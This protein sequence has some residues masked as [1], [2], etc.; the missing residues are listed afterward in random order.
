MVKVI[1]PM[2]K[3]LNER[4]ERLGISCSVL[5]RRTGISLR[6]VQR[7]LSGEETNPGFSTVAGL[8]RE[9]GVGV[10]FDDEVDVRTIRRRQ[11]ERKAER[12][13]AIVQGSSAL[14]AQALSRETIRDLREKTINELLAGSDRKLWAD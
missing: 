12:L 6:S 14:E 9:L 5:A 8:A 3:R 7:I 10:R 1:Q 2:S 11:A 13:L 4:R